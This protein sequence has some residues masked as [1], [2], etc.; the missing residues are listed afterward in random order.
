MPKQP[1]TSLLLL[2]KTAKL[3]S[4]G[5]LLM[6]SLIRQNPWQCLLI[7]IVM[8]IV[9]LQEHLGKI[10]NLLRFKRVRVMPTILCTFF[11]TVAAAPKAH[12]VFFLGTETY[13]NSKFSA[14]PGFSTTIGLG[15]PTLR[16]LLIAY[17]IYGFV[18]I[19]E[20]QNQGQDASGL[21]KTTVISLLVGFFGDEVLKQFIG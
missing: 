14:V 13:L 7:S 19:A 11:Y 4:L 3:L 20:A 10:S 5:I 2:P 12:A 6:Y 9:L 21:F 18:K 15:I 16:I 1:S 8:A 17:I